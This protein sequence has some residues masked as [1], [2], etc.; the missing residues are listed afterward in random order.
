MNRK[1][2]FVALV[3]A[4]LVVVMVTQYTQNKDESASTSAEIKPKAGFDAPVV[5]LPDLKGVNVQVGGIGQQLRFVNFWAAWCGPCELEAP[6]LQEAFEKY[7]DQMSFLGI[8]STKND[9]ERDA[10]NFVVEQKLTFPIVL[11]RKGDATNQYKVN[12]FPTSFVLDRNGKIL[13]RI[14]GVVTLADIERIVKTYGGDRN[15][16]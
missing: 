2:I 1:M 5:E 9:R 13:E 10:R 6:E 7:G 11:D 4:A 12:E 16:G 14:N 8:N 15:H 3:V